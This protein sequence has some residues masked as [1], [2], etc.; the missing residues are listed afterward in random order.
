MRESVL[1][2]LRL[3]T[4]VRPQHFLGAN[5][6]DLA[7]MTAYKVTVTEEPHC[8]ETGGIETGRIITH[9]ISMVMVV[10]LTGIFRC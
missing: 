3:R 10:I 2:A 6:E 9:Q 4:V 1:S 5:T 7:V 8:Y